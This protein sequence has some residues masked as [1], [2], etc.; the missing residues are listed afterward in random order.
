MF[1]L[2]THRSATYIRIPGSGYSGRVRVQH[3][4]SEEY[5]RRSLVVTNAVIY[6]LSRLELGMLKDSLEF[7]VST[8]DLE[9][10]MEKQQ[11]RPELRISCN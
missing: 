1:S 11:Y 4:T 6:F 5:H 8:P 3:S 7:Q 9:Q 2:G 10:C